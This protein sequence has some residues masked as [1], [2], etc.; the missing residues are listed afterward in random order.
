MRIDGKAALITG[1]SE[2]IGA[3][4][5]RAFARRGARLALT[6]RRREQLV[7]AGG[8]D[9][10]VV[11]GD[12]TDAAVRRQVVE[13]T[14]ARFGAIDILVN[15]A[16]VGLY[17]PAW[18]ASLEA[19]RRMFELNFFA[20]LDLIQL[21]VPH[22]RERRRGVIVNV[23]SIAGKVP[24]PWLTLYCASKYAVCALGDGLRMELRPHGI[25]VTT[26]CPG[27]VET[28]FGE[29]VLEGRLADRIRRA[30]KFA[31]TAEEC[32]E[33]IARGVERGARTVMAPRVGWLLV[34]LERLLPGVID[35]QMA[36]MY[37]AAE[38]PA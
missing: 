5:A 25:Q 10:L 19:A 20:L 30:R 16:G 35:A 2:G 11:A 12:L 21:V 3:A 37:H 1:A 4:C 14:L 38:P 15:N 17:T 28:G 24:F 31:I 27:H 18:Q 8:P 22:M 6:A 7:E 34:G 13:G 32:A 26:V 9:A 29:H 23:S 33:A 36:R